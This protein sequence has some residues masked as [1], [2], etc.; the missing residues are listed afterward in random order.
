MV[1]RI[2]YTG[3]L[4]ENDNFQPFPCKCMYFNSLLWGTALLPMSPT[5]MMMCYAGSSGMIATSS[6][7]QNGQQNC[8][9]CVPATTEN[10]PEEC[11]CP[12]SGWRQLISWESLTF[13]A[14]QH[15]T[16]Q[17]C[18]CSKLMTWHTWDYHLATTY[19]YN[20]LRPC[21]SLLP[22]PPMLLCADL[23]TA[24]LHLLHLW[25]CSIPSWRI[26]GET[27]PSPCPSRSLT[28]SSHLINKLCST[29]TD[30]GT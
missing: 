2:D 25:A 15:Q 12:G 20:T 24:W 7:T 16:I 9:L 23:Q 10:L 13:L 17:E 18:G 21:S 28:R 8:N 29:L 3:S 19:A 1:I 22:P 5:P 26:C 6:P 11:I 4:S 14:H 27:M 30:L